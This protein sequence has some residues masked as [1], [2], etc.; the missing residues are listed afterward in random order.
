M[1][2]DAAREP[3]F[4]EVPGVRFLGLSLF[5]EPDARSRL[6]SRGKGASD[7]GGVDF[8]LPGEGLESGEELLEEIDGALEGVLGR[9]FTSRGCV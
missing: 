1:S 2:G 3:L 6:T 5:P 9:T 8:L 4:E 7:V